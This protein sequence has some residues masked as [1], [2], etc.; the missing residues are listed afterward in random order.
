VA[1]GAAP[2]P[3]CVKHDG[4]QRRT[5]ID[6]Q[7]ASVGLAIV[8]DSSPAGHERG[9]DADVRIEAWCLQLI[10]STPT[11]I[12]ILC[13]VSSATRVRAFSLARELADSGLDSELDQRLPGARW[14][15]EVMEGRLV[16]APATD[17]E[18]VKAAR[19]TLLDKGWDVVVCLTDLPLHVE[20]RPVVAHANPVSNVAIVSVPALGA[21]GA[22]QR[23]REIIMRLLVRLIGS[24]EQ[25]GAYAQRA[26]RASRRVTVQR[27]RE[28]GTDPADE[29]FFYTARVLTGNLT[30]IGGMVAANEPWRLSLRLS[31]ALTGDAVR[32]ACSGWSLRISGGPPTLTGGTGSRVRRWFRSVRPSQP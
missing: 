22:R 19:M 24:A 1:R 2:T 3:N 31:R 27:V 6:R 17:A 12:R 26:G 20:Q 13:W 29:A 14:C 21:M 32:P 15:L 11:R 8:S 10:Q 16:Q 5:V 18:I 23:I 25:R 4:R 28:L 9:N 7:K 30:L